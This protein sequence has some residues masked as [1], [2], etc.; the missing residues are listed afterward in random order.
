MKI[1]YCID[2]LYNRGGME[3]IVS[4]CANMLCDVYEITIII[5]N[6]KNKPLAF[7]LDERIKTVDL[8]VNGGK[9]SKTDFCRKL[10]AYLFA[11]KQDIVISLAGLEMF[12]LP[13]IHDGSKKVMW[14][15]FA[16]DVSKMFLSERYSGLKFQ[17]LYRLHTLRRVWYARQFDKIVVLSK[18]DEKS[19]KRF[20]NNV[21]FIYN[22]ITINGVKQSACTP[23]RAISVGRLC[24]QKGF[25]YL[26]DAWTIV[27]KNHPEWALDIF[28]EG[29][30]KDQLQRQ[31]DDLNLHNVV[32]LRGVSSKIEEE[33]AQ[34][35][36]Y[37]MSSRAEGFP[38]VLLEASACGLP[39]VSFDCH[40]GPNEIITDGINGF[41]VPQVG[42]SKNL[43]ESI[44]RLIEDNALREKMG[45]AA[46]E[47][48]ERFSKKNIKKEWIAFFEELLK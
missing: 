29:P 41:L 1:A 21:T 5:A 9:E 47:S 27:N 31:I 24:W 8:V 43:A 13:K 40:L 32:A 10:S 12:F 4:V 28:G 30:D 35:S 46:L 3:R 23:K 16:F 44:C 11:N 17:L 25:D 7:D 26:I 6:Q 36:V 15:H 33:Y 18:A 37:V 20:C 45:K 42:D 48:S 2:S 22:P 39:M 38:L 34:H 14:F 19:W